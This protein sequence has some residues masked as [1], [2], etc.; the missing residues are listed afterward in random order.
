[1]TTLDLKTPMISSENTQSE[2]FFYAEDPSFT[3]KPPAKSGR[4]NRW[5]PVKKKII[6][7]HS[8]TGERTP[9]DRTQKPA[10]VMD[11]HSESLG[12]ISH[13]PIQDIRDSRN[14]TKCKAISLWMCALITGV[15][16]GVLGLQYYFSKTNQDQNP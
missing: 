14:C 9:S 7:V 15:A 12:N 10:K 1:M 6:R 8:I 11:F 4:L 5:D 16:L 2:E 13:I 3:V